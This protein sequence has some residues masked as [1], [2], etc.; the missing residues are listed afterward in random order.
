MSIESAQLCEI[1]T[2]LALIEKL[3]AELGG[4]GQE[5]AGI[6]REKL[7]LDIRRNLEPR[8]GRFTALL[9]KD[10]AGTV[11]GRV[12]SLRR[13]ITDSPPPDLRDSL[14]VHT[15]AAPPGHYILVFVNSTWV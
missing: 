11:V 1:D 13:T 4:E 8:S 9:A 12:S 6:D 3:L 15:P 10:E 7:E 2:V 5:F 14:L